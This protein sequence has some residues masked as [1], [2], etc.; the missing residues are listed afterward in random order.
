[1]TE[2]YLCDPERNVGCTRLGCFYR[3]HAVTMPE[4]ERELNLITGFAEVGN[5]CCKTTDV[6]AAY[7]W[8]DGN[9]CRVKLFGHG[10]RIK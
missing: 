1:M 2:L 3:E 5:Q 9:P 10:R 4:T 8:P 6:G 7:R